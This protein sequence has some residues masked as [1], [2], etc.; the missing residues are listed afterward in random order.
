MR[1]VIRVLVLAAAL[2]A[3]WA[4][5]P[6]A[7]IL[8]EV[9]GETVLAEF[10]DGV[11]FTMQDF[12]S[13]YLA[14]DQRQ[15]QAALQD[16]R[17]WLEQYALFRKLAKMAEAE[18][19]DEASPTKQLLQFQ[20]MVLLMQTMVNANMNRT[21]VD[22]AEV[23]RAYETGKDKY[24]QVKVKVIY[25]S[26]VSAALAK[27]GEKGLTEEQAKAKAEKLAQELRA[28][29]SFEKLVR[30]YS[31]DQTSKAKDGEFGIIRRTDKIPDAIRTA[32]FALK[33]GEVSAPVRQPNGFY[34]LKA[35]EISSRPLS[36]VRDEIYNEVQLQKSRAWFEKTRNETKV[37]IVDQAFYSGGATTPAP[38]KK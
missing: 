27:T 21:Q 10:D 30:E 17:Q 24:R 9:P 5:I 37:K 19:L 6:L 15:Q 3:A 13:V 16:R 11:K 23:I 31:E 8:P 26:F 12:R 29:A 4:Q 14:L 20:R 33:L 2:P 35:D 7:N 18:K 25:V 34:L 22:G 1:Y 28:G 32:V 36:E 38:A